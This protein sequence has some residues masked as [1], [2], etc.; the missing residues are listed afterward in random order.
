MSHHVKKTINLFSSIKSFPGMK[1]IIMYSIFEILI[2][3]GLSAISV[4]VIKSELEK[5][6][7]IFIYY[8]VFWGFFLYITIIT[9]YVINIKD[10]IFTLRRTIIFNMICVGVLVILLEIVNLFG[11]I[12]FLENFGMYVA[13]GVV[14]A[15]RIIVYFNV[16]NTSITKRFAAALSFP[17]MFPPYNN[18]F[19]YLLIMIDTTS[20]VAPIN[21]YAML[22]NLVIWSLFSLLF[23][24]LV[25]MPSHQILH[26]S[27]LELFRGFV[28]AYLSNYDNLFE[29]SLEKISHDKVIDV[30]IIEFKQDNNK[31][32]IAIVLPLIHP[33]PMRT[34]GSSNMPAIMIDNLSD[35]SKPVVMHSTTTHGFNIPRKEYI[36]HLVKKV[37]E[38]I[39]ENTAFYEPAI[40]KIVCHESKNYRIILQRINDVLF[41]GIDNKNG[42]ID[43]I[44]PE[45]GRIIEEKIVREL[46]FISHTFV[47]DMHSSIIPEKGRSIYYE[48]LEAQ[49]IIDETVK[50]IKKY[51][52]E[53]EKTYNTLVVGYGSN[54]INLSLSEGYGPGGVRTLFFD[55]DEKQKAIF[56]IFDGNNMNLS[57]KKWLR[58][59][60]RDHFPEIDIIEIFTTDTHAVNG[61]SREGFGYHP[62][63]EVGNWQVIYEDVKKAL[64]EAIS[65]AEKS[66]VNFIKIYFKTKILGEKNVNDLLNVIVVSAKLAK[67]LIYSLSPFALVLTYMILQLLL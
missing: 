14:T 33:G 61:I 48:D 58:D 18:Y 57:F 52:M 66:K 67:Y 63:G 12:I 13:L 53:L 40:S 4:I 35:I 29:K 56:I 51:K 11:R 28:A 1:K 27:G 34:V 9:S 21:Y 64:E 50:G 22:I 8:T 23:L 37:K 15:L 59:K 49:T 7:E 3:S 19:N 62:V 31:E 26:V 10:M 46:P 43:D 24:K 45:I 54:K 38:K 2:L 25:D 65:S 42:Y 36:L 44:S 39:L 32:K 20:F 16:G 47:V 6:M 30:N 5:F 60:I 41:L 55:I 17:L